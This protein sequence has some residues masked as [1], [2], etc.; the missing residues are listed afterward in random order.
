MRS[1][2]W[3]GSDQTPVLNE[4]AIQPQPGRGDVLIRV[5]AAA[6]MPTELSWYP[7]AHRRAGEKR[8]GAMLGTP[9]TVDAPQQ[10]R[11]LVSQTVIRRPR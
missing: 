2:S 11:T 6:V 9:E 3:A 1:V 4:D 8:A 10:L 5:C 7:T